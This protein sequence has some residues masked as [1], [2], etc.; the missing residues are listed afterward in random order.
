MMR[1]LIDSSTT[2]ILPKS[3]HARRL[4]VYEAAF[5]C[6]Y[7]GMTKRIVVELI[8]QATLE[9]RLPIECDVAAIK[10]RAELSKALEGCIGALLQV[11]PVQSQPRNDGA[12]DP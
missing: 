10:A 7:E 11:I 4:Q 3:E 12:A 9:D 2:E 6:A 1:P 5:L 8:T